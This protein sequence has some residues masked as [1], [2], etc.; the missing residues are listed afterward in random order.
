MKICHSGVGYRLPASFTNGL[1]MK[2]YLALDLFKKYVQ[3]DFQCT[4]ISAEMLKRHA[5]QR[6]SKFEWY[7][8]KFGKVDG[9][10][11]EY[12]FDH[13]L[14]FGEVNYFPPKHV[15]NIEIDQLNREIEKRKSQMADIFLEFLEEAPEDFETCLRML[16]FFSYVLQTEMES[17]HDV[18]VPRIRELALSAFA[19][20]TRP[21]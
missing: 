2:R 18:I 12:L 14:A 21:T 9:G 11:G 3:L 10:F 19:L 16:G 20:Q 4:S 13:T 8:E 1:L 7:L 6:L 15:E 17:D 5:E